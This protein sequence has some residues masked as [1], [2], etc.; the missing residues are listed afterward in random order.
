MLAKRAFGKELSKNMQLWGHRHST[1]IKLVEN[2]ALS[3][4]QPVIKT[5]TLWRTDHNCTRSPITC[6]QQSN[7]SLIVVQGTSLVTEA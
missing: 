3:Q 4:S 7:V 1:D 6:P 2:A 5:G